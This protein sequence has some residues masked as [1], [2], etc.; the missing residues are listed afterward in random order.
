M[1]RRTKSS[2]K[3]ANPRKKTTKKK[4]LHPGSSTRDARAMGGK[5]DFGARESD[6]A[7]RDYTSRNT[8]LSDPGAAQPWSRESQQGTR[9]SGAGARNT[10]PGSA[11]GGDVDTDITGVGTGGSSISASGSIREPAGPDDSTG[12]SDE[13]ASG[14]HAQG[15][16]ETNVG[17]VGGD[18]P[19]YRS[20]IQ[21]NQDMATGNTERGTDAV[22]NPARDDDSFSGE[23]SSGEARGEDN[24]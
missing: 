24:E 10:G 2:R 5:G 1:P 8:K 20:I 13:F 12:T 16:N 11:S 9:V 19:L 6:R 17:K 15:K 7:E 21:R 23:V 18:K 3:S 14:K 22:N 4:P